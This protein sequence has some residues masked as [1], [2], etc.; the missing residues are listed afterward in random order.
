M[1]QNIAET[2]GSSTAD[3]ERARRA[4]AVAAVGATSAL[5]DAE[6]AMKVTRR[7]FS[8]EYKRRILEQ[9][10]RCTEPGEIGALLR[11]EGLYSSHLGKWRAQRERGVLSG[12]APRKRGRKP[13]ERSAE[14]ARLEKLERDNERLRVKLE[15][16]E[17]IIEVQK[18]VS[19]LLG[20]SMPHDDKGG[21]GS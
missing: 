17:L 8:G 19:Q 2:N 13:A 10:D 11:R 3:T 7:R 20:I 16:A 14:S 5:P 4:S 6:V 9:A 12:L 15:Q 21:K 1:A 18:K